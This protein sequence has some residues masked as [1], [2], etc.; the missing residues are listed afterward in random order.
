M[1]HL[2]NEDPK[3]STLAERTLLPLTDCLRQPSSRIPFS[4]EDWREKA[5][6][7]LRRIISSIS[8]GS[9]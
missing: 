8:V 7:V 5:T 9:E 3:N 1:I 6:S 2:I 4:C